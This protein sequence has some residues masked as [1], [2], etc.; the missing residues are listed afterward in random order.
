MSAAC[1][2]LLAGWAPD[3]AGAGYYAFNDVHL[4]IT[5]LAAG[6]VARAHEG[7]AER[8]VERDAG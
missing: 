6:D 1:A 4:V 5:M 2:T 3:E 7:V 8:A